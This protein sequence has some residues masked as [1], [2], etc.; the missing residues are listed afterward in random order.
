M[1]ASGLQSIIFYTL[2]FW[3]FNRRRQTAET[4]LVLTLK[5]R[6]IRPVLAKAVC[7]TESRV[8]GEATVLS[9]AVFSPTPA[10]SVLSCLQPTHIAYAAEKVTSHQGHREFPF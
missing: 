4:L 2:Q 1:A 3:Q 8:A 5:Y 9:V 6:H 10:N 7:L